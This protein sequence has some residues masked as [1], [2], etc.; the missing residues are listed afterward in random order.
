M[1]LEVLHN[2]ET[3]VQ[4]LLNAPKDVEGGTPVSTYAGSLGGADQKLQDLFAAY[5]KGYTFLY[6]N[7]ER[8]WKGCIA[9]EETANRTRAEA[10]Q[11]ALER[12]GAGPASAP[13]FVWFI[14]Y[15]WLRCD[16]AN[17]SLSL[18]NRVA[19]EVVMLKWLVDANEHDNVTLLTSMPYWP[20]GLDESGEWC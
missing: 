14:R 5:R 4:Q 1:A 19:P 7:S 20:M 3:A 13:E 11:A 12:R 2:V 18:E 16:K 15:F 8:W 6:A 10:V 17:K 9:A